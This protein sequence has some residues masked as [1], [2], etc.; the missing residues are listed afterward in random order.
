MPS[1]IQQEKI[2]KLGFGY[3][4]LPRKGD[5]FDMEQIK[6]MADDYIASGGNYFD[7]AFVYDGSE[8]ALRE[9]VIKRYPRDTYNIATKLNLHFV[10][11]PEQ[12]QE[13]FNTSL[14]RLGTDYVDFYLLH[15]L[16]AMASKKAEELGAWAYLAELKSKG[17]IRHM[18]F[19]F[20]APP[21]DLEEILTKHPEAEFV[22]MQLN[23][24]DWDNPKVQARAVYEVARKH[25]VPVI[26]MEPIKG[27]MLT[28]DASPIAGLLKEANPNASLASWALRFAASLE[29]VF[30]TLSGMSAYEQLADNV[31]TFKDFKPITNEEQET[32]KKAVEIFDSVPRIPC[33]SCRYCV[34]DC[35]RKIAIPMMID[36]YNNYL[37]YNTTTNLDHGYHMATMNGGKAS[38]CIA[39]RVCE[40]ICPQKIDIVATLELVAKL[41]D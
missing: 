10:E 32:L 41:F 28:G 35:P 25:D 23:Y 15:G 1:T 39:C 34:K 19:S 36:T 8:V 4:R 18:G 22:Q 13:Q 27:G 17:L 16:N 37:T 21:E 24:L 33:T 2:S 20:H 31:A 9:S 30:V 3:M 12:L 11:K 6:K 14:E 26:V 29:G 5:G 7:T 38:D 40:S